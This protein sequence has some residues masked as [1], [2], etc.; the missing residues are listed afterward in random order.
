MDL[1]NPPSD[2][3]FQPCFVAEVLCQM[4]DAGL[5]YSCYY[6]IRDWYVSFDSFAPFM[7][8]NGTAFMTRWWNRMPQF[9]GLF[10][11]QNQV[12]PAYFSFKLLSRL[13]GERLALNSNHPA[14]HGF[15]AH[16]NK[17]RMDNLVL[18]NFSPATVPAEVTL[19]GLNSNRRV[20]HITLDA[21]ASS[22]D[23]NARLR[24]EPFFQI[25]ASG[26]PLVVEL[27]PY[28]VHYWSFE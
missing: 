2:P 8:P 24:P 11:Y 16:D 4:K 26:Q 28:A 14:V 21:L 25:Q 13:A 19:Q 22:S 12:R 6:H 27:G 15:A 23:E 17:L 18:W 9:D 5:D 20:R 10:D 1:M 3:R 7:S